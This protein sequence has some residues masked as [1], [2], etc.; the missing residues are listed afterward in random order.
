MMRLSVH[1]RSLHVLIVVLV[2]EA[3]VGPPPRLRLRLPLAGRM[4]VLSRV[5]LLQKRNSVSVASFQKPWKRIRIQAWPRPRQWQA[6]QAGHDATFF[7]RRSHGGRTQ[8]VG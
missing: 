4:R 1:G 2:Q 6:G 8:K 5:R 7:Q 3:I